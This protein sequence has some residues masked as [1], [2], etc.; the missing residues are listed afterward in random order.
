MAP[1]ARS[2]AYSQAYD[3]AATYTTCR[4]C[5]KWDYDGNLLDNEWRC[6]HCNKP[7]K[8]PQHVKDHERDQKYQ[9]L[10]GSNQDDVKRMMTEL[11]QKL[12]GLGIS[13]AT[14]ALGGQLVTAAGALQETIA[15]AQRP[16]EL[17]C[18]HAAKEQ[19]EAFKAFHYACD[20]H[21]KLQVQVAEAYAVMIEKGTELEQAKAK[22]S[23]LMTEGKPKAPPSFM[24]Q[25]LS[26]DIN[27]LEQSGAID[28]DAEFMLDGDEDEELKQAILAAK[29]A[30]LQDLKTGA[31]SYASQITAKIQEAKT[32]AAEETKRLKEAKKRKISEDA[33][34]TPTTQTKEEPMETEPPM[35]TDKREEI[36]R[37]I[38]EAKGSGKG[39]TPAPTA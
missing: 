12:Q 17:R 8:R 18:T 38:R 33:A 1:K 26:E 28:L 34:E 11:G 29:R 13:G 20:R 2:G 25:L 3:K 15:T 14:T 35:D 22:L 16:V 37:G 21:E 31:K 24:D 36:L 32:K 30:A 10:P 39:A 19:E 7:V 5:G 27:S 6:T 23:A 4:S 9:Q